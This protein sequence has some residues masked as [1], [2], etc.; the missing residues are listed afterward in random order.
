MAECLSTILLVS[1]CNPNTREKVMT[2]DA[3][4]YTLHIF[5]QAFAEAVEPVLLKKRLKSGI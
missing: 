2:Y 1:V 4:I 3:W 5:L